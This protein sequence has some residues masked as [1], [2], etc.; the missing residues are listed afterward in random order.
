MFIGGLSWETREPQLKEY[1]EKFGEVESVNLKLHPATGKSRCFAFI[2]YKEA[3]SVDAV[4]AAAEHVIN[5]KKVDVK[6][7]LAKPGKIFVGGL[8]SDMTDDDI[9]NYFSQYGTIIEFEM[10]FDKVNS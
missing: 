10:P 1:F 6:K 4:F 8:K 7:A 2:T 3:L 5:S 9:R